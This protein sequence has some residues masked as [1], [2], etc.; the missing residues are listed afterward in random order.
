MLEEL[1][2]S[3]YYG[4]ANVVGNL[5]LDELGKLLPHNAVALAAAVVCHTFVALTST[6]CGLAASLWTCR[7]LR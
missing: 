7:S 1:C 2:V 6:N 3:F 4:G 5:F